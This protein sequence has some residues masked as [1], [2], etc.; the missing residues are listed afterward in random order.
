MDGTFTMDVLLLNR[1]ILTPLYPFQVDNV[2][3][4]NEGEVQWARPPGEVCQKHQV[5]LNDEEHRYPSIK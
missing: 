2:Q 3:D 1:M 5:D 4:P